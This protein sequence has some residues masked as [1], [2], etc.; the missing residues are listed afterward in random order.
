MIAFANILFRLSLIHLGESYYTICC[1]NC[2]DVK[3]VLECLG[4]VNFKILQYTYKVQK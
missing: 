3:H 1:N 2:D 4:V